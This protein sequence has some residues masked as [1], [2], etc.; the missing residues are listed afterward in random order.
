MAKQYGLNLYEYF[1]FLFEHR[2]NMDMSDEELVMLA[3]WSEYAQE[4]CK[5]K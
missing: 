2:P 1:K 4:Q 3:P 5:I